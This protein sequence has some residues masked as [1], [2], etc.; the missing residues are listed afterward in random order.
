MA[1]IRELLHWLLLI[2]PVA[3]GAR[4]AHCFLL[5]STDREQED[6]YKRRI[7]NA[8]I[9]LAIAESINGLLSILADYY[10]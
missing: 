1:Q 2:L 3:V 4:C 9:F 6:V 10:K 5:I 8:L 7:R